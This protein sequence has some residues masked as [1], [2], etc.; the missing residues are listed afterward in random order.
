MK[1][2]IIVF[3]ICVTT[4]FGKTN[5]SSAKNAVYFEYAGTA[6]NSS[7]NYEFLFRNDIPIR[8]GLG[9]INAEQ[10]VNFGDKFSENQ[11]VS[12]IPIA[13][14]KLIGQKQ[15]N[16][17]LGAGFIIKYFH[18]E[19]QFENEKNGVLLN[20]LIG[21]RYQSIQNRGLLVRLT[22]SPIYQPI[23]EG[24]KVYTG[25]SIGYLF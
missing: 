20:G 5:I 21:Y 12:L 8:V 2:P 13:I 1:N 22:L 9:Y 18:R 6:L 25:V 24:F 11:E 16:L 14:G 19:S 15:H 17:E 4:L 7:V 10:S 3:L 23:D